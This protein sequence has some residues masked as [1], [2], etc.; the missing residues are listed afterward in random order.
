VT[1]P[2]IEVG[3]AVTVAVAILAVF[4]E[5]GLSLVF[6][7]PWWLATVDR[8]KGSK[9]IVALLLCYGICRYLGFD[10]ISLVS[11]HPDAHTAGIWLTAATLAGGT[12][13]SAKL[14]VG[15]WDIQSNAAKRAQV[16]TKAE[17]VIEDKRAVAAVAVAD[18]KQQASEGRDD[19]FKP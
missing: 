4:I 11:G 7:H 1:P 2:T 15:L 10:A 14:F 9:E 13:G 18:A 5:R 19:V 6:E 12:K 16:V 17:N 8:I 3:V